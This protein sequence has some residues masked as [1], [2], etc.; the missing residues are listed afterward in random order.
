MQD[1]KPPAATGGFSDSRVPI[2]VIR[3][4]RV[5][6]ARIAI[7]GLSRVI[8]SQTKIPAFRRGFEF[9]IEDIA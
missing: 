3:E 2:S 8:S 6:G 9:S 7:P 4:H 1:R 5:E